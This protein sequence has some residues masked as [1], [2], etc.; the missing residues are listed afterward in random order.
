MKRCTSALRLGSA[1]AAAT[2]A[3]VTT[4]CSEK[5]PAPAA[6]RSD[7]PAHTGTG[8][9]YTAPGWQAGDATSWQTQIRTRGQGQ[10]EYTRAPAAPVGQAAQ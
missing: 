5:A 6:K 2:L 10:N 3:L 4:A 1:L 7:T 8:S 9:A